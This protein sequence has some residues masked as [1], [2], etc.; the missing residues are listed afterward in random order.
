MGKKSP[1]TKTLDLTEW[2]QGDCFHERKH[3][4]LGCET[5]GVL[6]KRGTHL[7][8]TKG[9]HG[10]SVIVENCEGLVILTQTCDLVRDPAQ[11]PYLEVAPLQKVTPE[12]HKTIAAKKQPRYVNIPTLDSVF[13]VADLDRVMT[14]DKQLLQNCAKVRGCSGEK[15]QRDFSEAL[16]R[17]RSRSALPDDFVNIVS[18]F[19]ERC[20]DK[21]DKNTDEGKALQKIREIRVQPSPSWSADAVTVRF[22]FLVSQHDTQIEQELTPHISTWLKL[23]PKQDKY[24]IDHFVADYTGISAEEY[25]YSDRFDLDRLS[26]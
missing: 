16:A 23:I 13:L 20:I 26:N 8:K 3:F 25:I 18:K 9:T 21:H 4:L 11:R 1:F 15:E 5:D 14:I 2:Q 7:S 6:H 19:Q 12:Q 22:M 17:K 24:A 10:H